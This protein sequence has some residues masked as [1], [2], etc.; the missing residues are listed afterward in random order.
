MRFIIVLLIVWVEK[1]N[2]SFRSRVV[3]VRVVVI[4]KLEEFLLFGCWFFSVI[5]FER[6]IGLRV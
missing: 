5:R 1:G 3:V 6:E 2:S 4:D